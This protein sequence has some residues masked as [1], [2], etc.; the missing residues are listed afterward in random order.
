MFISL[1]QLWEFVRK[2]LVNDSEI[3]VN[4]YYNCMIRKIYALNILRI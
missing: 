2:I 3:L 1:K 4:D